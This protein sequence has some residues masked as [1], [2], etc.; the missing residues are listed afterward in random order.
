MRQAL[1]ALRGDFRPAEALALLRRL[2][3]DPPGQPL[4]AKAEAM[5]RAVAALRAALPFP[6]ALAMVEAERPRFCRFSLAWQGMIESSQLD[7]PRCGS[8][9]DPGSGGCSFWDPVRPL[10]PQFL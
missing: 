2:P 5:G 4:A 7:T 9:V 6:E 3:P 1:A 8:G 10:S